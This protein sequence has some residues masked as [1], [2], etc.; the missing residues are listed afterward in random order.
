MD[1][2]E[3]LF[4]K[5]NDN[6]LKELDENIRNKSKDYNYAFHKTSEKTGVMHGAG[7]ILEQSYYLVSLFKNKKP[8][9]KKVKK[10][11]TDIASYS[12]LQRNYMDYEDSVSKN[13][14]DSY[15]LVEKPDAEA[16][17]EVILK[18]WLDTFGQLE[19]I[20][21]ITLSFIH[22]GYIVKYFGTPIFSVI[23]RTLLINLNMRWDNENIN[24][25]KEKLIN[26]DCKSTIEL[27][28]DLLIKLGVNY[29]SIYNSCEMYEMS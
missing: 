3:E 6:I 29:E 8:N 17:K 15:K 24:L 23:D 12:I 5:L 18:H 9:K 20:E 14:E 19:Y 21:N 4:Y 16:I 10:V 22:S 2:N 11:L 25:L 7:I 1:I 28:E 13:N 27:I 26:S